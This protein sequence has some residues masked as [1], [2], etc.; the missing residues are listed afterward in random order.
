MV[1]VGVAPSWHHNPIVACLCI[2]SEHAFTLTRSWSLFPA[3]SSCTNK[4]RRCFTNG[5]IRPRP[6]PFSMPENTED[7]EGAS[8][9]EEVE[10]EW[11]LLT[12]RFRN[13]GIVSSCV[14]GLL[15]GV[16]VVLFNN[17]VSKHKH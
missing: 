9:S 11:K 4:N 3:T 16:A 14:V 6:P 8:G 17:V 15:T 2:K 10:L 7:E 5:R 13:S 12:R 1:V